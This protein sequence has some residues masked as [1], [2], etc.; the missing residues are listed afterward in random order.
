[1]ELRKEHCKTTMNNASDVPK[2]FF[3]ISMSISH[4][5]YWHLVSSW[6]CS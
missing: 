5:L 6:T 1:M 4:S 2:L 3:P